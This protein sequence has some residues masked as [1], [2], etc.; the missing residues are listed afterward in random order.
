[1]KKFIKLL[2]FI[3]L[4]SIYILDVNANSYNATV[5]DKDGVYLRTGAGTN[6]SYKTVYSYNK[7]FTL[8]SNKLTNV[9]DSNCSKGWVETYYN[10]NSGYYVCS[11]CIKIVEVEESSGGID[12]D[13]S[14]NGDYYTT[15]SWTTRI[16]ENYATVRKSDSISS[17]SVDIIYLGTDVKVLSGPTN[18]SS[19]CSTGWYKISYYNNKTG[20]VCARLVDEYSKITKTD[21]EYAKTLKEA[22]FPD[23]YIPY[24]TYLH[25][26]HP[27]WIFK[28][29]KSSKKFDTVVDKETGKNYT[30]STYSVYR[31][32]NTLKENPNWYTASSSMTAFYIDPRN[33]L[34]EKNIFAFLLQSYD[35]KNH[36]RSVLEKLFSGTYLVNGD[37]DYIGYFLEAAEEYGISPVLLAARVKQEGGTNENYDAVSG[38]STLTYDG[39]SLMGY[40]NYYNIGAYQDSKT[41]SAV[42]RGLAVAAGI[43][44]N[45]Y[46]TPWDTRE[47]AIKYGARFITNSYISVGQDTLYYQ[48]FNTKD[49]AKYSSYTNQYMTN[50]IAPAS[51]SLSMYYA[52]LNANLLDT[53]WTFA[54]PVYTDTPDSY[55]S[56]P[57]VGNTNNNLSSLNVNDTLVNG[58]DSD[59]LTY[60][61]YV[62]SDV[63]EIK[64]SGTSESNTSTISGTGTIKLTS[65]ETKIEIK[66]TSEVGTVK[67]Y[68][69][70]IIKEKSTEKNIKV[71]E[72]I[73]NMDFKLSNGYLTNIAVLTSS[74]TLKNSINKLYPSAK[75][76]IT[77]KNKVS[78]EDNLATGDII[79]IE[80]GSDK[81]S[82]TIVIKGDV[83]GDGKINS[84]D[85]LRVQKHILKYTTLY[86]EY[87]DASDVSYDG[88]INSLD[89]LR[90][91][92][93]IL[94][95]TK[96]K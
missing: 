35:E 13:Y 68:N 29:E 78:K 27:N 91:Q 61:Y 53:A 75:V 65:D 88:E 10:G 26:I 94:G 4:F 7:T 32:N 81:A 36:T 52:Y 45:Y 79:T 54:I 28:A 41:K 56:H 16:N 92:K 62:S 95:Y 77:D 70:N 57:P 49:S 37:E 55:T 24:L 90:V 18:K 72:I 85:L 71:S 11:N 58:F 82:Y 93:H 63:S 59:I 42:T 15:K 2:L 86:N 64:I 44:D 73:N 3:F 67:T 8:V 74:G 89:L 84:I 21:S 76:T 87:K 30:Q 5:I 39:K 22:G 19:S 9:G 6:Y 80:S 43:V 33:Y 23:S 38:K 69:L 51:E 50:I 66:V 46:G 12:S 25:S 34:N 1:M 48:K 20:Y 31:L 47:K 14:F 17:A 60:D 83:N 40:Y 96:I